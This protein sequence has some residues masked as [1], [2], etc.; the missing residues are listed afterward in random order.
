[1]L[2]NKHIITKITLKKLEEGKK[3][4]FLKGLFKK[5]CILRVNSAKIDVHT[6]MRL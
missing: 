3:N 6:Y 4:S 5:Q 1:M 2:K